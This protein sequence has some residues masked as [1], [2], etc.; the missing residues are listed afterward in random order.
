MAYFV[1]KITIHILS[2]MF[3]FYALSGVQFDKLMNVQNPLK[4]Q[5]LLL[6]SSM[7]LGYLVAQFILALAY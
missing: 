2:F 7:G 5:L 4:A 6:F 3:S 1:I